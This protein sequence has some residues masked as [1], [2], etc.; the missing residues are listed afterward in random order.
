[1]K[2]QLGDLCVSKMKLMLLFY[3]IISVK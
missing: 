2:L 3:Y 1:L